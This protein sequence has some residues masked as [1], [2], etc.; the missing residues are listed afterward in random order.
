MSELR[1]QL[2]QAKTGY[3]AIRFPGDLAE[4][5]LG[6]SQSRG[7]AWWIRASV[8]LASAAGLAAMIAVT[9][10]KYSPDVGQ[11]DPGPLA[12]AEDEPM[13]LSIPGMPEMPQVASIE[14]FDET[15]EETAVVSFAL[16]GLP[17]MPSLSDALSAG[18]SVEQ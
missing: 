6:T 5:M 1:E 3:D 7:K 16:P 2:A 15:P 11:R 13:D 14:H 12:I 4:Q 9:L 8:A 18:E 10:L 17:I